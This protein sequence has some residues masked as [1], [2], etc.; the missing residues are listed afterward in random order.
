MINVGRSNMLNIRGWPNDVKHPSN[1]RTNEMSDDIGWNQG[2]SEIN[3]WL[4]QK[5][6]GL[7]FLDPV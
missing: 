2:R 3:I 1:M 7:K 4:T 6:T 5:N